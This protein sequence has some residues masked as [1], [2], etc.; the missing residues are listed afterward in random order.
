M[1][2][3]VA[4]KTEFAEIRVTFDPADHDYPGC[5]NTVCASDVGPRLP[6]ARQL[7]KPPHVVSPDESRDHNPDTYTS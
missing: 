6:Q 7:A 4:G 1:T 2:S 3:R 5:S